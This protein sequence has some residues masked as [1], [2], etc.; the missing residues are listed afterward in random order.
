MCTVLHFW[1]PCSGFIGGVF[2]GAV[3]TCAWLLFFYV[4]TRWMTK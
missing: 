3:L 2:L 4:F 1:N